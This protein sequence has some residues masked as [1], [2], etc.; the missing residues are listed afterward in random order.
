M[1]ALFQE[2][3]WVIW[4]S[5]IT[6]GV[7]KYYSAAPLPS[8]KPERF[9]PVTCERCPLCR[10]GL[11]LGETESVV[12]VWEHVQLERYL[13]FAEREREAKAVLD[14]YDLV[15]RGV[16]HEDRRHIVR[17]VFL[18]REAAEQLGVGG[19]AE[20]GV[21]CALV[22]VFEDRNDGIAEYSRVG[23]RAYAVDIVRS[24]VS[25]PAVKQLGA[26]HTEV[27][28]CGKAGYR[29]VRRV[30]APALCVIAHDAHGAGDVEQ[31]SGVLIRAD[32]VAQHKGIK[33][34]VAVHLRNAAALALR[35]IHI[36]AAGADYDAAS[37]GLPVLEQV[38]GKRRLR[39]SVALVKIG[40]AMLPKGDV[41]VAA[42][43]HI[44]FSVSFYGGRTA[45]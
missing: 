24:S 41:L 39:L 33:A 10:V 5:L 27:T 8:S 20:Q 25:E 26:H 34:R 17:D 37:A 44:T 22:Y 18:A 13:L 40:S 7:S 32:A 45:P 14:R 1:M 6:Y 30:D 29:D 19:I 2:K 42:F 11:T 43:Y 21:S 16:P 9:Q 38:W 36:R 4:Y 35:A 15:V 28:A 23:A 3:I 31:L 12:A